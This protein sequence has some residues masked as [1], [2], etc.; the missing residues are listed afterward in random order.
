MDNLTHSLV[1][2]FLARAGFSRVTDRGAAVLVLA[3]NAPDFDIVCGLG[4]S[5]S[6]IEWHRNI[7]HSLL[8]VPIMALLAVAIVRFA[9]RRPLRWLNAWLIA[10]LGVASH[11]VLDLTNIY[12]VRLLLPFSGR[13]FHWDIAPVVDLSIWAILLL[14][15]AAP[16]LAGLVGSEIGERRR[17]GGGGWALFS[18]VLLF[19][20]DYS[21]VLLHD[22]A[23]ATVDSR[24]YN[25]LAPRRSGA[26]PTANPLVWIGTAELSNA[27]V[28]VPVDLRTAFHPS[29]AQTFYKAELTPA[30]LAARATLPFQKFQQFVQ[31][32][33]WVLE[34]ATA[35]EGGATVKLLDLR[36]GNP[37]QLGFA[38]IATVDQHSRVLDSAFGMGGARPR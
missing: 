16:A 8:A 9:G 20:Y 32:P 36:F 14:G 27:Y 38:A 23:Q 6:Y 11:L 12:G 1:G 30:L 15:V 21:R 13:W 22:R 5:V 7:T 25:G 35:V 34:P 26:F 2:L 19:A 28:Q 29:D 37:R 17:A 4:G 24:I 18:L 10:M 3:A 31:Y 33:L